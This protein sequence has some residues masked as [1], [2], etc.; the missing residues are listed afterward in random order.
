MKNKEELYVIG[1]PKSGNTWLA[2]L[3]SDILN[4]KIHVECKDDMINSS[5]NTDDKNGNYLIHK[6]HVAYNLDKV[7][8]SKK[9]YIVRDPRAVMVSGFFHNN[10]GITEE[11][12]RHSVKTKIFFN[13]EINNLT[14]GWNNSIPARI[15]T[16]KNILKSKR[17]LIVGSWSESVSFW[18]EQKN[19]VII[20]YENLL[21]NPHLEI[22]RLLQE[23]NI[24]YS[25]E[26]LHSAIERQSFKKKKKEFLKKNDAENAKFLRSGQKNSWKELLSDK[27]IKNIEDTHREMMSKFKYQR[28]Y[29]E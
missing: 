16:I 20:K 24:D 11:M 21:E 9:V 23:L 1:F 5:E 13:F 28:K 4:S 26:I 25:N 6:I 19:I 15:N 17:R 27:Q 8:N 14:K 12:V 7:L 29:I 2:R 3:L 22:T 18:T 10:R